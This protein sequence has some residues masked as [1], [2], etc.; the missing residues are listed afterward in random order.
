MKALL[1]D[2]QRH[3]DGDHRVEPEPAGEVHQRDADHH[4]GRGPDVGDQVFG[5]GFQCDGPVLFRCPEH[6]PGQQPV[7][8]RTGHRQRQ[9][10]A[11]LLDGLRIEQPVHRRPDD[12]QRRH[13]DQDA[14]KT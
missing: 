2:V 10:P 6:H 7:E 5:I 13:D 1:Q 3:A 12:A 9:T 4:A 14:L 8:R 11:H